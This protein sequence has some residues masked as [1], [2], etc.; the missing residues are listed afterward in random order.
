M[1][2]LVTCSTVAFTPGGWYHLIGYVLYENAMSVVRISAMWSGLLEL[3][4]AHEWVVTS[5]LGNWA[6]AK[7]K[8]A[9]ARGFPPL[10][11]LSAACDRSTG[12]IAFAQ[13]SV[14][15]CLRALRNIFALQATVGAAVAKACPQQVVVAATKRKCAPPALHRIFPA[16]FS[17]PPSRR[18]TFT[19][20]SSR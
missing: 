1:P 2:L 11:L 14:V 8:A 5:K 10:A 15:M 12:R 9:T 17:P 4:D 20:E 13:D 3:S 7:A 16:S 6:A 19:A 18:Q